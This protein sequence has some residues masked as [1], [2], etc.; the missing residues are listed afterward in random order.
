MDPNNQFNPE[1]D[2]WSGSQAFAP[3]IY[4][5]PEDQ[6]SDMATTTDPSGEVDMGW[7]ISPEQRA[8]IKELS[9]QLAYDMAPVTGEARAVMYA[10]KA[11]KR[12]AQAFKHGKYFEGAGHTAE[13]Y[14][15]MLGA[16]PIG[17]MA[18]GAIT[19]VTRWGKGMYRVLNSP[20]IPMHKPKSI[21]DPV[22][23]IRDKSLPDA[24]DIARTERHIIPDTSKGADGHFYGSPKGMN[25]Q[26]ELKQMR[27]EFDAIVEEGIAGS[28]WYKRAREGFKDLKPGVANRLARARLSGQASV[29]SAQADPGP[30]WGWVIQSNNEFAAGNN[31]FMVRTP[32]Q[33][34]KIIREKTGI[35]PADEFYE[36][37]L[38][39]KTGIYNQGINPDLETPTTG[40]NDIWHGRAFGYKM[41]DGSEFDRGCTPQE[42]SFLDH[43]TVL[44]VD[45]ANQKNLGGRS[46][47]TAAELQ[48]AAWINV[49]G[50]GLFK[51][52]PE[53]YGNDLQN[54]MKEAAKTYPDYFPKYG[55]QVTHESVPST[56]AAG[57]LSNLHKT[58]YKGKKS[59]S[60]GRW[61]DKD[62]KDVQ[63][64]EMGML[65][66]GGRSAVGEW[67]GVNN[68]VEV[69]DVQAYMGE[70][71]WGKD[72]D[73]TSL[74][75]LKQG[76]MIKGFFDVQ[77]AA[78]FSKAF[79]LGSTGTKVGSSGSYM[80]NL[81]RPLKVAEMKKLNKIA[82]QHGLGVIDTGEGVT[83]AQFNPT[84]GEM[85]ARAFGNENLAR[86]VESD[87]FGWM[88]MNAT[89]V[90]KNINKVFTSHKG[91]A[92]KEIKFKLKKDPSKAEKAFFSDLRN[93]RAKLSWADDS[94]NVNNYVDKNKYQ[95]RVKDRY[96]TIKQIKS[97]GDEM[98]KV[99]DAGG[100]SSD[101]DV[102]FPGAG[103][104][105]A[106]VEGGIDFYDF[107]VPG[108]GNATRKLFEMFKKD[109]TVFNR[110]DNS[111]KYRKKIGELA[112]MDEAWAKRQ[113]DTVRDDIQL[114]KRLVEH[115]GFT[116]L[117]DALKRGAIL[118]AIA[119]PMLMYGIRQE[120]GQPEGHLSLGT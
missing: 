85:L 44:A 31:R 55:V 79:G 111:P 108:S 67:E 90:G 119:G 106:R 47:W 54:A 1:T 83:L 30:N 24:I 70:G 65:Q 43:E 98:E 12:A 120:S 112:D 113:S 57:H 68:P 75:L 59:Y 21:T 103:G 22:L 32:E 101:L 116:A 53:K 86:K 91:G 6:V 50:K 93:G 25:T 77:D 42:H 34:E 84:K 96:V 58:G 66:T 69:T 51:K 26:M 72:I 48:A 62:Q 20:Q 8:A 73:K 76:S 29:L 40:T 35:K 36:E 5:Q 102:L 37:N 14:A 81:K 10:D 80:I 78:A 115:G 107:S 60:E 61:K 89:P 23:E 3:N 49:K 18:L 105:R 104:R 63:F 28:D 64:E 82:G 109:P 95:V 46:D 52:N 94:G 39:P 114:A 15:E 71:P 41:E 100:L 16:I 7:S 56:S 11:A 88:T 117:F 9:V 92:L 17:G 110:L 118:P 27:E 97:Q 4:N 99:L 87:S 45:R 33:S 19:D 74:S 13:Q 38:G 2:L